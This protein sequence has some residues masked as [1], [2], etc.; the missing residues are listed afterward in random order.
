MTENFIKADGEF[1]DTDEL[2]ERVDDIRLSEVADPYY[3]LKEY[4]VR[5]Y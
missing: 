1:K 5:A 2:L 3:K 4:Q